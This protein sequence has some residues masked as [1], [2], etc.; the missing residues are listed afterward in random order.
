MTEVEKVVIRKQDLVKIVAEKTGETQKRTAEIV[1]KLFETIQ[2][3]LAEGGDVALPGFG[4]F[5][6]RDTAARTGRNPQTGEALEIAA[7]KKVAF[8]AGKALKDAVRA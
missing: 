5:T 8:K 7:S 6:V 4:K 2:E 3:I 1:G